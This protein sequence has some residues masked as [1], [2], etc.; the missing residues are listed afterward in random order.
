M[1]FEE[2]LCQCCRLHRKL[3]RSGKDIIEMLEKLVESRSGQ[4]S[5]AGTMTLAITTGSRDDPHGANNRTL[6][7]R[8]R[9]PLAV[10]GGCLLQTAGLFQPKAFHCTSS[11][12]P[13]E[14]QPSSPPADVP[15]SS[16]YRSSPQP[17]RRISYRETSDQRIGS[18]LSLLAENCRYLLPR[19]QGQ[20]NHVRRPK[21]TC[22]RCRT[23]R[24]QLFYA[25]SISVALSRRPPAYF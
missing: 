8:P 21:P 4:A 1:A 3:R 23:A 10:A 16:R 24:E 22:R 18:A 2:I 14:Q 9:N 12:A 15:A 6:T 7:S 20:E 19:P 25:A 13:F 5:Q 17:G 11:S